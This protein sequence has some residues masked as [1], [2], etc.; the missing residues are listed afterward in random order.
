MTKHVLI[1][2]PSMK[3]GGTL[4][5][6][7]S[8]YNAFCETLDISVLPLSRCDFNNL[9][10]TESLISNSLLNAYNG[11][12][13][14]LSLYE[15]ILAIFVKPYK[16]YLFKRNV[17]LSSL[18]ARKVVK[19]IIHKRRFDVVVGFSEGISTKLASFFNGSKRV[20]WIHCDYKR[21]Y[22]GLVN[23]SDEFAI[24]NRFDTIV[25]V[26]DYTRNSFLNVFPSLSFKTVYIHNLIDGERIT[27]MSMEDI[28]D[29]RF[30]NDKITIVSVGRI[31]PV[32]RFSEIPIIASELKQT[33]FSFRWYILG[34]DRDPQ[35]A[36]FLQ[37]RIIDLDVEDDVIWLG[38]K[39][40]PYAYMSRSDLFVCL[41]SSEACPMVFNEAK[42]IG[43]PIIT[44]D[45]GSADEFIIQGE[46]G[47][48][49]S[50]SGLSNTIS[51]LSSNKQLLARIRNQNKCFSTDDDKA[52]LLKLYGFIS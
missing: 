9:P 29:T 37:K 1:I 34:P 42:V 21:Y 48:I 33:G 43:L 11:A 10:F 35:E 28:D 14:T 52:A 27:Q 41:S 32:K 50:L 49:T 2:I 8:I 22:E 30:I 7:I 45:F 23:K 24:Y 31:D 19:Q 25:C 13:S 16:R 44:T 36:S 6:L 39:S 5:S 51:T 15:K 12:F 3:T 26:S 47:F 38:E 18:V 20:S 4:S 40:N 46:N 17:Q